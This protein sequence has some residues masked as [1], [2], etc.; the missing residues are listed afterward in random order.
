MALLPCFEAAGAL[1]IIFLCSILFREQII[2]PCW[3]WHYFQTLCM[4]HGASPF[5]WSRCALPI[6]SKMTIFSRWFGVFRPLHCTKTKFHATCC[7]CVLIGQESA[8]S[9]R[10]SLQR[11][12]HA[13]FVL[14]AL[15]TTYQCNSAPS[16]LKSL[17]WPPKWISVY[18]GVDLGLWRVPLYFELFR[19]VSISHCF[20][21]ILYNISS[22][23]PSVNTNLAC[24][25]IFLVLSIVVFNTP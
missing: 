8:P 23:M 22:L 13:R 2:V 10:P 3:W 11:D 9:A 6:I 18:W 17:V 21:I 14:R 20:I 1:S 12:L 5:L 16:A 15:T 7:P 19:Y 4:Q 25:L 24:F